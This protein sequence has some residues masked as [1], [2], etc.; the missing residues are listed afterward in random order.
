MGAHMRVNSGK[1]QCSVFNVRT[2]QDLLVP[3]TKH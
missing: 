1:F 3:K 2:E